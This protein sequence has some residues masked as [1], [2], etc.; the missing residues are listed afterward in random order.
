MPLQCR[1]HQQSARRPIGSTAIRKPGTVSVKKDDLPIDGEISPFRRSGRSR[2]TRPKKRSQQKN[3]PPL[4]QAEEDGLRPTGGR[5]SPPLIFP[6]G[7][8]SE[9]GVGTFTG[10]WE[11]PGVA[12]T[13]QGLHPPSFGMSRTST[14]QWLGRYRAGPERAPRFYGSIHRVITAPVRRA[15]WW[16]PVGAYHSI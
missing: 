10:R 16:V 12:R 2:T 3:P 7:L 1:A 15:G 13:S 6:R 8:R 4:G 14:R 11:R 9:A 5:V